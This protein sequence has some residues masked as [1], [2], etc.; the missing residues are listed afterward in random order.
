M[1]L[2]RID[3]ERLT[4]VERTTFADQGLR[5]RRDLQSLLKDHIEVIAPETLIV[6]EEL[7]DWEESRRR[8]DLL[9]IDKEANLV[10]FE[11]K[12][13]EDGGHMELQAIRYAAMISGMTFEKLVSDYE[14]YLKKNNIDQDATESLL[15]FLDWSEPQAEL[16]GKEVRIVL[17]SGEFSK[18]LTTSVMWLNDCGLDIRCVRMQPYASEGQILMDVQTV[19]PI[20]EAAEYQVRIREKKQEERRSR[21]SAR[22]PAKFDLSLAGEV[23][24]GQTR[25][26]VMYQ[27]VSEILRNGVP[28]QQIRD[29]VPW[30]PNMLKEME[31]TLDP[32][33]L[34]Q[35]AD[36]FFCKEGEIFHLAG[37]TLV[38]SNWWGGR[39]PEA[40]NSLA[41][42]FPQLNI[43]IEPATADPPESAP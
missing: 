17:A 35:D 5:E 22:G 2:Y 33:Q 25:R 6:A 26:Q 4:A 29:A 19:I 38:L 23:V 11:L 37:K 20:P 13:T 12:R 16:F 10:V 40:V 9:G 1:P 39:T 27:V 18:E 41:E 3:K 7:S 24:R 34:Q 28:P 43:Q 36:R 21:K 15:E 31:G 14:D 30:R 42:A 32:E 8:I